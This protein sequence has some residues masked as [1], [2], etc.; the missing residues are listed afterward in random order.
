MRT[1]GACLTGQ[2]AG[3]GLVVVHLAGDGR[4]QATSGAVVALGAGHHGAAAGRRAHQRTRCQLV[5][6]RGPCTCIA[7]W[8]LLAERHAVA[9]AM[10]REG[11]SPA[12]EAILGAVV[13][14]GAGVAV[15]L[16]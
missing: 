15:A 9:S 6:G 5:A 11:G 2:L 10:P 12:P 13:A 8:L 3:C 1:S 14:S 16:P 7:H 4:H